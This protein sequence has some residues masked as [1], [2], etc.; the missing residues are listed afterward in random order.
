VSENEAA[1]PRPWLG[2]CYLNGPDLLLAVKR[3]AAIHGLHPAHDFDVIMLNITAQGIYPA[4]ELQRINNGRK[5]KHD[6]ARYVLT[7]REVLAWLEW[8][9]KAWTEGNGQ[10]ALAA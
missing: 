3:I 5:R 8:Y 7:T 6:P 10:S 9:E 1:F 4:Y 2:N